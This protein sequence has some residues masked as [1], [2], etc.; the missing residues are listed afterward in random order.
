[1]TTT[2][3]ARPRPALLAG[4]WQEYAIEA[5]LL[6]T[7][8]VSACL[9][10]TLL[11]HPSSPVPALV[12]DP[13]LRRVLMGLAMGGTAIM[14]NYSP[15]GKQS[16]AHYNPIVT[17]TF[18]RLGKIAPRDAAMYMA[19]QFAGSV[20]GVLLAAAALGELLADSSVHYAVTRPGPSG[21]GLAFLGEA[22]ISG[23]LMTVVLEV[24][25]RPRIASL[26]GACAGL[27]VAVFI[28]FEAPIS[29]MSMN[30]A[31]TVGS[32]VWAQDWTAVW[33]YF[34]APAVGMLGAAE[35]YL[36]RRGRGAV[37]CAKLHHDNDK[38]CIHCEYRAARQG[39][40][41][42]SL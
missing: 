28:T 35:L 16:G 18:T 30:P 9:F 8:M 42:A 36:R 7:F 34:A 26:T 3:A 12:P 25:N 23:I 1:M 2:A 13:F 5:G 31:R 15:W 29:G 19:A 38:R 14:L 33:L 40:S 39:S 11:F 37:F 41:A 6:G 22:V 4:H 24:S 20:L 10:S 27:L 21:T 32:A 17:L